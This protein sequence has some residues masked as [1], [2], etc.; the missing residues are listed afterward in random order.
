MI[1]FSSSALEV[2]PL[3]LNA[4]LTHDSPSGPVSVRLTAVEAYLG[5]GVGP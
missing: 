2:A 4:V 5:E 3:V 1:D